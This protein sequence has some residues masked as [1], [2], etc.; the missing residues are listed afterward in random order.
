MWKPP[1]FRARH[2]LDRRDALHAPFCGLRCVLFTKIGLRVAKIGARLIAA[3][4]NPAQLIRP[5]AVG[6]GNAW[7]VSEG[8]TSTEVSAGLG[9]VA[10]RRVSVQYQSGLEERHVVWGETPA[11]HNDSF[12]ML[13]FGIWHL[14]FGITQYDICGG[15]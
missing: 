10:H 13:A 12:T 3:H 11:R 14:A 6:T 4:G 7:G 5:I 15:G 1:V 2:A 9:A 8:R